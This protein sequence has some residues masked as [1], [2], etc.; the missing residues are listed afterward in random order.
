M[1]RPLTATLLADCPDRPGLVATISGFIY[2]N[3]GNILAADQHSE[4]ENK[5][6]YMRVVWDLDGFQLDRPSLSAGLDDLA[7][8]LSLNWTILYS[9]EPPRVA[10]F[11]SKTPHC[12]Y[13][14]LQAERLQELGGNIVGII[15]NHD[16]LRDVAGH[17]DTPF[18]VVPLDPERRVEAE[19]EMLELLDRWEA[20]VVV[21]ARYMQVLSPAFVDRWENRLINIHH[22]FLP[23][24][25]GAQAYRQARDRGVKMIGVTAHYATNRL[26]QGPIIEQDLVRVSHRDT[27]D[28]LV[29][30]GRELERAVLTRAVR[31]HLERRVVVTGARTIVFA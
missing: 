23:A 20:D 18:A 1:T 5:H 19:A 27:L 30:K 16:D 17:F 3:G 14:L 31:M 21:L 24:F 15:S 22:S 26:D 9:D 4:P 28:D 6:F 8:R 13:D 12:L 11:V 29:R 7:R 10:I 2:Q 25:V